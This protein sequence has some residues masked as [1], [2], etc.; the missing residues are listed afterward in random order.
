PILEPGWRRLLRLIRPP[1]EAAYAHLRRLSAVPLSPG[2]RAL[3]R[4]SAAAI[5]QAADALSSVELVLEEGT[6]AEAPSSVLPVLESA[7]AAW[8]S[9]FRRQG[10]CL[11]REIFPPLPA[12]AH[13]PKALRVVLYHLLRNALEA[14]PRGGKLTV[15]SSSACDASL[16]LEFRDDGPGYP[17][18]WLA[19]R[20]QP[21]AAPRR[22]RAGL[23]LALVR[24]TMR[25]WGGDA[26]ASNAAGGRGASLILRFAPPATPEP[27]DM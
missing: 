21:F 19:S 17:A 26:E 24:K 10:V 8:E 4:L 16:R 14:L 18:E 1:L 25:R 22:G 5:S 15:R 3:V 12:A 9:S 11:V 23:G 20:F 13:E 7:L 6:S 2:H 27:P